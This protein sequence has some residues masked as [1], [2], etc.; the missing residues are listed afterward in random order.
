MWAWLLDL[1]DLGT[2]FDTGWSGVMSLPRVISLGEDRGEEGRLR[3]EVA[4]EIERLRY[5]PHHLESI[6]VDANAEVV[7]AGVSGDSLELVVDME[8]AN[9]T[10]FGIKVCVS[11]DG[12]EQTVI[13]FDPLER[14][15]SIDTRLSGPADSPKDIET[16]PFSLEKNEPLRLRVFIDKSVVEVFANDRQALVRRIYPA[17]TDSS[18]VRVFAVGGGAIVRTLQS[19]HISPSNPY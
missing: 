8:S 4:K 7:V 13:S 12:E 2:R 14:T 9:A 1:R 10:E 5:R 19:W 15:L 16:A 17:R 6:E 3:I 11:P 18:G